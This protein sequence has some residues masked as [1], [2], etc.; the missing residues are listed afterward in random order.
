MGCAVSCAG[1]VDRWSHTALDC[2]TLVDFD[3]DG[4]L[5][6]VRTIPGRGRGLDLLSSPS[7]FAMA[8]KEPRQV[9]YFEQATC[10]ATVLNPY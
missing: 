4:A 8:A 7:A 6:V 10:I 2:W 9:E 5:D 1:I 3:G